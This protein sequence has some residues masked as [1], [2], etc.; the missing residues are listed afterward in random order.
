MKNEREKM[1]HDFFKILIG[2]D[3]LPERFGLVRVVL[4]GGLPI[5]PLSF[6]LVLRLAVLPPAT[7]LDLA[8]R[9]I[10]MGD[11]DVEA[12]FEL[13]GI[14]DCCFGGEHPK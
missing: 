12:I 14:F 10:V 9:D 6:G 3:L 11:D 8:K 13:L 2:F 1:S 5:A 7:T 4:N